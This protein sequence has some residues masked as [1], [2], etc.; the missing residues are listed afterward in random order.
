MIWVRLYKWVKKTGENWTMLYK[1]LWKSYPNPP[2][3]SIIGQNKKTS[4]KRFNLEIFLIV[5]SPATYGWVKTPATTTTK[6]FRCKKM[7]ME[8]ANKKAET[9]PGGCHRSRT[10]H[11][12]EARSTRCVVRSDGYPNFSARNRKIFR[13]PFKIYPLYNMKITWRKGYDKKII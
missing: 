2:N 3:P 7:R 4:S 8:D 13:P 1:K 6:L 9:P 5:Y 12:A 11:P 10:V